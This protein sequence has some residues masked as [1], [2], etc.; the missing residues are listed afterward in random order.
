MTII[1]LIIFNTSSFLFDA[2]DISASLGPILREV[3]YRKNMEFIPDFKL[4]GIIIQETD[5]PGYVYRTR[6]WTF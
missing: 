2:S 4:T 6:E 1:T 3:E 5:K